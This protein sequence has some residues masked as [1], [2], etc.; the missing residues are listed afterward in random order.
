LI[1]TTLT[2]I[3][4]RFV[5]RPPLNTLKLQRAPLRELLQLMTMLKTARRVKDPTARPKA[6]TT[7]IKPHPEP[8][9][10]EKTAAQAAARTA[11][12]PKDLQA[13][14]SEV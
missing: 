7:P 11:L 14:S 12:L 4:T 2:D 1:K 6:K 8:M 13:R 10:R 5:Y 9:A 3:L